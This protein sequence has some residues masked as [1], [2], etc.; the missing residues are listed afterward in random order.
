[1]IYNI[2][3]DKILEKIKRIII[4]TVSPDKIILFWSRARGDF[5]KDSDYDILIIKNNIQN[6]RLITKKVNYELVNEK[7]DKEVD[8][9]A[10]TTDKWNKNINKIGFI[11]K[12]INSEGIILYG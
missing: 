7:I 10:I 6:E 11:Y 4:D 5:N 1:M 3:D 9:L 12:N 8:L 2:R